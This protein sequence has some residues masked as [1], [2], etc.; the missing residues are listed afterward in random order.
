[1]DGREI[2]VVGLVTIG[3][4]LARNFASWGLH[5]AARNHVQPH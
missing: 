4:G 1:M 2:V 3:G 5:V